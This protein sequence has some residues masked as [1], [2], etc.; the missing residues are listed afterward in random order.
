MAKRYLHLSRTAFGFP[1]GCGSA[2]GCFDSWDSG[3]VSLDPPLRMLMLSCRRLTKKTDSAEPR[4]E[5][6]S[7]GKRRGP[8]STVWFPLSDV[9]TSRNSRPSS[10][11]SSDSQE[12]WLF[13][14][15]PSPG[16][17][18]DLS[19]RKWK[20][21]WRNLLGFSQAFEKPCLPIRSACRYD[22]RQRQIPPC[23]PSQILA[24]NA[25]GRF[26]ALFSAALQSRTQPY[27]TRVEAYTPK[28]PSQ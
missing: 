19:A 1:W 25:C 18:T 20:V 16:W 3:S 22:C 27:R 21:Q 23:T 10:S 8:L 6:R 7:L 4:F 13:W 17:Q 5:G 11:P 28:V 24:G 9:D 26:R 12:R 14:C 15:R 2:S